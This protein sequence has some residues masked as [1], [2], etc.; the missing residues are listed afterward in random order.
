MMKLKAVDAELKQERLEKLASLLNDL[1]NHIPALQ[2]MEVGLNFSTRPA[3]MDIV[4][5][6]S[7][8]DEAGLEE[9]RVHPEHLEVLAY[10]KEVVEE[11]RVVDYWV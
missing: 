9:Y 4:L 1:Q 6:S 10:I 11:S 7:F 5:S 8:K 2:K 3:A